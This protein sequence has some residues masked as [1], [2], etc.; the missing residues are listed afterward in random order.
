MMYISAF[1]F[2]GG[3]VIVTLMKKK[4]VDSFGWLTEDEM[5]DIT[6]MAQSCPGAIAVNAAILVGRQVAGAAGIAA[7]VTGT[8][9]P[10]VAILSVISL[11]YKAFASN[12]FV[13]FALKGMQAGVAAV[14][15]DVCLGLGKNA[16]KKDRVIN[17]CLMAFA[18][19]VS[20]FTDINI[21]L[22]ILAAALTGAAVSLVSLK[23]EGGGKK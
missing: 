16:L 9:I 7:A 15:T 4:F 8:V 21:V 5:L 2:G 12:T 14:L 6:A 10:P 18:F 11:F 20:F 19:C 13:A 17:G 22:V 23:K 3:F 1:T